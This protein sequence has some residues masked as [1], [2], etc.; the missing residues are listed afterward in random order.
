M[1]LK[2]ITIIGVLLFTFLSLSIAVSAYTYNSGDS[3]FDGNFIGSPFLFGTFKSNNA[4]LPITDSN[5]SDM[6]ISKVG[7]SDTQSA[8][9]TII[10]S[11]FILYPSIASFTYYPIKNYNLYNFTF[12]FNSDELYY[13]FKLF[14]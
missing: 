8:K 4:V 13:Q 7:G 5:F 10:G 2:K 9:I 6:N 12:N 14:N 3:L 1:N 11:T